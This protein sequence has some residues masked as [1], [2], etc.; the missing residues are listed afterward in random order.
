M[1]WQKACLNCKCCECVLSQRLRCTKMSALWNGCIDVLTLN[2]IHNG[3]H[4]VWI[5]LTGMKSHEMIRKLPNVCVQ[6]TCGTHLPEVVLW[7]RQLWQAVFPPSQAIIAEIQVAISKLNFTGR[8]YVY[9]FTNCHHNGKT[10]H[11]AKSHL[12]WACG[13]ARAIGMLFM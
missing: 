3:I 7:S 6:H 1:C 4:N 13:D 5:C 10:P 8:A 11:K 12:G 9:T 2:N